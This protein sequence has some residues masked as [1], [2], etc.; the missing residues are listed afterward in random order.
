MG[1]MLDCLVLKDVA[2]CNSQ[3]F[4]WTYGAR[5]MNDHLPRASPWVWV[6]L[7]RSVWREW[8]QESSA[9]EGNEEICVVHCGSD[10]S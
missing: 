5:V 8:P 2:E 3:R 1:N 10:V 9:A 7:I 4:K 6:S